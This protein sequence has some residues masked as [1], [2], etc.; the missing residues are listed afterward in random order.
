MITREA[1]DDVRLTTIGGVRVELSDPA[2]RGDSIADQRNSVAVSDV[3]QIETRHF[4]AGRT[5]VLI[6][7]LPVV[8]VVVAM[9]SCAGSSDGCYLVGGP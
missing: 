2:M 5:L 6:A 7:S 1:P 9:A 4:S 3:A 8:L